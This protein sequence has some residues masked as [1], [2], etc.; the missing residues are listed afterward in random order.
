MYLEG[1]LLR[2]EKR[3]WLKQKVFAL[4]FASGLVRL[5][6]SWW[7]DSLTVLNYHRIADPQREGED[8]FRPNISASPEQFERQMDYLTRWFRVVSLREVVDWLDGRH[9]LPP[10]AALITFDDGYLDNYTHAYP[11]LRRYGLPAVIF[12]ATGYLETDRPFY[13]DLVA[14]CLHHTTQRQLFLPDGTLRCWTCQRDAERIA[15]EVIRQ[16]KALPEVEKRAWLEQLPEQ[17]GVVPPVGF[18]AGLMLRWEQVREMRQNGIEFGG[19]TMTHPI[20]TCISL[21]QA[22]QE[23]EGGTARLVQELGEIPLGFAYPNGGPT[24]FNADVQRLV[25]QAGYRLA[26][27]LL[28]GPSRLWEVRQEPFAVRRVFISYK[29]T[30]AEFAA[31]LS[32]PNRYRPS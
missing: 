29:H 15:E 5:G 27:T 1:N 19:H 32:W 17:S 30:L 18:F 16:L 6:R 13:W 24:D 26:F 22:W 2:S 21:E 10:Y 31:L 25:E 14:Y 3:A 12:L 23:I 11:I 7:K 28:H 4:L 8:T 9:R 20:L